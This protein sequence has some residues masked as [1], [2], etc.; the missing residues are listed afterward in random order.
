MGPNDVIGKGSLITSHCF[1]LPE[2]V[3]QLRQ[4]VETELARKAKISYILWLSGGSS[5]E[6][7]VFTLNVSIC[8]SAVYMSRGW[9]MTNGAPLRGLLQRRF[10][11]HAPDAVAVPADIFRMQAGEFV[12]PRAAVGAEA[13]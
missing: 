10:D 11:D 7:R 13:S 5:P 6:F 4:A 8:K 9:M 2:A 3:T 1:L 12:D